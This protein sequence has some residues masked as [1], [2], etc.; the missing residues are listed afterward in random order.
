[1]NPSLDF[2]LANFSYFYLISF[3]FLFGLMF[4]M[5]MVSIIRSYFTRLSRGE[6]VAKDA[7]LFT[8]MSHGLICSSKKISKP[9]ISKHWEFSRS[10]GK[11]ALYEC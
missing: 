3:F 6:S 11:A 2:D 7:R 9:S 4:N 5:V 8:S 1:M 10:S